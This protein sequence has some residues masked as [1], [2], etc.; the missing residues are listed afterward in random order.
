MWIKHLIF[1]R[2]KVDMKKIAQNIASKFG[3]RLA[4]PLQKL[5]QEASPELI[6][7][8]LTKGEARR[9]FHYE[10]IQATK[11]VFGDVVECGVATGATLIYLMMASRELK[12]GRNFWGFDTFEGF[13]ESQEEDGNYLTNNRSAKDAYR[14]CS[15]EKLEARLSSL[16]IHHQD[17]GR[18]MLV[19]GLI[20]ASFFSYSGAKVAL[21]NVDVDLYAP[22]LDTLNYFWPLMSENGVVMLDEYSSPGDLKKWPGSKIA[23]DEFCQKNNI[24][25]KRHYTGRVFLLKN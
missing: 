5:K 2:L 1:R 20:P 11:E 23:I 12:I 18:G 10:Q 3:Y 6:W 13:P 8:C 9:L 17:F 4:K 24:Q 22:T 14:L 25:L 19:K 21:L 15:L 16:G 7:D